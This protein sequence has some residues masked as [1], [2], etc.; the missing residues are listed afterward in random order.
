MKRI[1]LEEPNGAEELALTPAHV[2]AY[3]RAPFAASA[4]LLEE[5]ARA[6]GYRCEPLSV[7]LTGRAPA[8][9]GLE[10]EWLDMAERESRQL[11]VGPARLQ[12]GHFS[13]PVVN[14]FPGRRYRYR[15]VAAPAQRPALRETDGW[16]GE[17][18]LREADLPREALHLI[19]AEGSFSTAD[20]PPRWLTL[21]DHPEVDN[22]RDLGGWRGRDG[23]RVRYGRIYRGSMFQTDR[24]EALLSPSEIDYLTEGLGVRTDLDLRG[25]SPFEQLTATAS[26]GGRIPSYVVAPV[27]GYLRIFEE[28]CKPGLAACFHTLADPARYPVYLHCGGGADRTGTIAFV[29]LGLLGVSLEDCMRDFELTSFTHYGDPAQQADGVALHIR[30]GEKYRI[31][32][33]VRRLREE[34]GAGGT[35]QEACARFLLSVGLVPAE[36]DC[37]CETLLAED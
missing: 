20:L 27:D 22:V 11:C 18:P 8:G 7:A 19:S 25:L 16:R 24:G 15:L 21:S 13:L 17:R 26:L 9:V 2:Q 5:P 4:Q 30:T 12:G 6:A 3:L 10:V 32:D 14:L 37:I 1:V 33:F 36:L 28:L 29:L 35:L 23:R 31:A 34:Y